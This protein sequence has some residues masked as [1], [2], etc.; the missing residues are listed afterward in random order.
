MALRPY[1]P[2]GRCSLTGA[3]VLIGVLVA[4]Q[5]AT[6]AQQDE[7]EV[8]ALDINKP[9]EFGLQ[10]HL[11]TTPSG[12]TTPNYPGE[13][14]NHHGFRFTPEFSY[15]VTSDVEL[16]LYLPML[17][18]ANGDYHFVG[19]KYRLK[20]LPVRPKEDG[21]GWFFG[22]N[23]E[24]SRV[25]YKFSASPWTTELRPIIGYKGKNWLFAYNPI[26]D[27]DLSN[28]P[29]S[30]EPTFVPSVKLSREM[31]KGISL[32]AEYYS[33]LGRIAHIEPW[34]KQDNRIYGVIDVDMKPL[35]FSFGIGR[36]LTEASD[37]WTI[38]A[39]IDVP[40]NELSK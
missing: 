30:W 32:G 24:L 11:N 28:K 12:R 22:T 3:A 27:W 34:D 16:G 9:G 13:I 7:I 18:D 36:G 39:I 21:E 26:L 17:T 29:R 23:S 4:A 33:D 8:Y 37:K 19:V 15:G 31:F 14:T 20:W 5:P 25:G 6:A 40:I 1:A 35:V 38:K 10:W 2:P